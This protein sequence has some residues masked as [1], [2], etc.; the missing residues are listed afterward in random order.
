MLFESAIEKKV[1]PKQLWADH[2]IGQ[3][4]LLSQIHQSCIQG[5]L[6]H[7]S[8]VSGKA[9]SG[10]LY[11]A[12]MMAQSLLC[13]EADAPCGICESC[14]K[15]SELIHPD[16]H[17][18][19]PVFAANQTSEAIQVNWKDMVKSKPFLNIYQWQ[20]AQDKDAKQA[21]ITA[22]EC[23][24]VIDRMYLK[25]FESNKNV[26]ILW[27]PEYLGKE[28]NILL[29]LLE[30][31]PGNSFLILVTEDASAIINTILSRAH[32]FKL[33]PIDDEAFNQLF[34]GKYNINPELVLK[35][36]I[37]SEKNISI[38][39]QNLVEKNHEV[40]E[41]KLELIRS[42]FQRILRNN[43]VEIVQWV[44][45]FHSIGKDNQKIFFTQVLQ[46]LSLSLGQKSR[47]E[48]PVNN[49]I[50]LLD[51]TQK[52]STVID[53]KAI[54]NIM[55]MI[56]DTMYYLQRNA[57]V[58]IVMTDMMIQSSTFFKNKN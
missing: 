20:S 2:V 40:G 24:Y 47:N 11:V 19:L 17:F 44:D 56:E 53:L 38:A 46:V 15:V 22:A 10:Q 35:E 55:R 42:F 13:S 45:D 41:F 21:N 49:K 14:H 52:L 57:S 16:L 33:K 3:D 18:A 43:P 12:L 58:K 39:Y 5:K 1:F 4:R 31:P 37:V 23:R 27:L 25:P 36:N 34:I 8:L 26:L 51:F 9:G 7:C 50:D 28:G 6:P 30:E 29:K 32:L 54:E 48:A